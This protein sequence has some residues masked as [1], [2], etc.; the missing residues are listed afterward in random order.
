[1]WSSRSQCL[2][3]DLVGRHALHRRGQ[4][5]SS[6]PAP[7][8]IAFQTGDEAHHLSHHKPTFAAALGHVRPDSS[9]VHSAKGRA[10]GRFHGH[11]PHP[12]TPLRTRKPLP[13]SHPLPLPSRPAQPERVLF[14]KTSVAIS[15]RVSMS[16]P[17][18]NEEQVAKDRRAS[19]KAAA[20]CLARQRHKA[21]VSNLQDSTHH[22]R[23]RVEALRARRGHAEAVAAN[24]MIERLTQGLP[25]DKAA[26]LTSWLRNSAAASMAAA[27][28]PLPPLPAQILQER[29]QAVQQ[30]RQQQQQQQQPQQQAVSSQAPF[31]AAAAGGDGR[32]A[33]PPPRSRRSAVAHRFTAGRRRQ[34]EWR[35]VGR[36][37]QRRRGG[38]CPAGRSGWWCGRAPSPRRPAA[39][40]RPPSSTHATN[41]TGTGPRREWRCRCCRNQRPRVCGG[42]G[43]GR[44]GALAP[45]LPR[46]AAR[47]ARVGPAAGGGQPR[48]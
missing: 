12:A 17:A 15:E 40:R 10:G 43:G 2:Y 30:Q 22:V 1:M 46:P 38:C 7:T 28:P 37:C 13:G 11:L 3:T 21:F 23:Y 47:A 35:F 45:A 31:A 34:P 4:T 20:A 48:R 16:A 18:Q 41:G 24:L 5:A 42:E 14:G 39:F 9:S 26:Q 29:A 8:P 19:R 33:P 44:R 25:K 36:S 6:T 27:A 32:A